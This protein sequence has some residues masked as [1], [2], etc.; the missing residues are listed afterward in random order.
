MT[1]IAIV[2]AGQSGLQLSI[3]LIKNNV[4]VTLFS[5]RSADEILNGYA[6]SSQAIFNTALEYERALGLNF[7]EDRCPNNW[8]VSFSVSNDTYQKKQLYWRGFLNYPF[9]SI[10]QRIKFS[11]WMNEFVVLGG[12]LIVKSITREEIKKLTK[13]YD[14]VIIATGK[15]R[16]SEIFSRNHQKSRFNKP[17][18]MLSLFYVTEMLSDPYPGV[19]ANIIPGVGEYFTMPGLGKTGICDMML[20]EKIINEPIDC[21]DTTMTAEMQL[22]ESIQ[23]LKK[24]LPWEGNRCQNIKLADE[25]SFLRGQYT[26]I[27]RYPVCEI[28]DNRFVL[29]M[30]DAVVLNDPIAG[31]GAN[32]ASQCAQIY[33]D[34]ILNNTG[35]VFDAQWMITTFNKF[36]NYAKWATEWSNLLLLPPQPHVQ[37]LL[38]SA[39]HSQEL[40]NLLANAFDNLE[41]IFPWILSPSETELIIKKYTINRSR[42]GIDSGLFKENSLILLLNENKKFIDK[43][44]HGRLMQL[45]NSRRINEKFIRNKLLSCIQLF[46]DHFQKCVMLRHVLTDKENFKEVTQKHLDEEYNHN[47]SLLADRNY[48]PPV[49]DPLLEATS[50]WFTWKML[51]LDNVEKLL[52]VHWVLETSAHVFFTAAHKM[53]D[54]FKETD[55]FSVHAFSDKNHMMMGLDFLSDL[56]NED[57][58]HLSRIQQQGWDMLYAA[59][60]RIAQLVS[61]SFDEE[62]KPSN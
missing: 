5:D 16:L 36:W 25:K 34:S 14:L 11:A 57:Y 52:L 35:R 54:S 7:W 37:K 29:A 47:I 12:E 3:A 56:R 39:E 22:H 26:P 9:Q 23:W 8:T 19:R 43:F 40:S 50:A 4:N 42:R 1:Q 33:M 55:Y 62:S 13:I 20:F 51:L 49:W 18:R 60:D 61:I 21:R 30:G 53:M 38:E 45:I 27:V 6:T 17:M 32:N 59:C 44:K 48:T 58:F 46:S 2:G 41:T 28:S 24:Y 31:Q 15:G 10:D